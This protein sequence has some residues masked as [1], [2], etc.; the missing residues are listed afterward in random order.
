VRARSRLAA[1]ILFVATIAAAVGPG[2]G[3]AHAAGGERGP[4][5]VV[6]F[7]SDP[8]LSDAGREYATQSALADASRYA[9][10]ADVRPKRGH[11][12]GTL[13]ADVPV[14]GE[15]QLRFRVFAGMLG[16]EAALTVDDVTVDGRPVDAEL[17][18]SLLTVPVGGADGER[19]EVAMRFSYRVP[20]LESGGSLDALGEGLD[21]AETGLLARH[22]G[23]ITLG[24]WFPVLL[25]PGVDAQ[26]APDGFGDIGNFPAAMFRARISV[27]S[28]WDVVS[29]GVNVDRK[30]RDGRVTVV[31]EGGG[32]RDFAVYAGRNRIIENT[33]S[34][35]A[36][37]RVTAPRTAGDQVD[38]VADETAASLSTLADAFGA[39]PW[40]ELDVVSVPFAGGVG[41]M[42]WPGMIWI[43][44]T[45]FEGGVPGLGDLGDL[46]EIFEDLEGLG[47]LGD[48][49][50]PGL[51]GIAGIESMR[52]F[53]VAHEVAH[54]WWHA[55]VGNDAISAPVVDEP[56]AQYSACLYFEREHPDEAADACALQ[57]ESQYQA[58]RAFGEEDAPADQPSDAFTSSLQYGGVVYGKAPGFYRALGEL[59]G[60]DAVVA[61]LRGFVAA[62]VFGVAGA[63][64]LRAAL[65]A[66]APDRS[67][68]IDALWRRWIEEAHGDEDIGTGS[69]PGGLDPGQ[70]DPEQLLE[71]LFELFDEP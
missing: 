45:L 39:Y 27:P 59:I 65:T 14:G 57:T 6:D 30:E 62:N 46:G 58:M 1:V 21:P 50:I 24:H 44:S 67:A 37:V 8:S 35:A 69:L 23:G 49:G 29:G 26:P 55:L 20:E 68:E 66:T 48:L 36:A 71:D 63:D 11:V 61:G 56:L 12:E 40:S 17:D 32:L 9:L 53:V 47:D 16:D 19:V 33:Q 51:E 4:L 38:G 28:G 25:P 18:A 13:L 31:E 52:E 15:E 34:G 54:Q 3:A 22:P 60:E 2:A 5:P 70:I 42:E 64:D 41:G 10:T 43:E 7:A